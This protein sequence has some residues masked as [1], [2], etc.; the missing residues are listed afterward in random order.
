MTKEFCF[1]TFM[2]H[3]LAVILQFFQLT[4]PFKIVT[5]PQ[6]GMFIVL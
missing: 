6:E 3:S 2:M 1:L 5:R 4:P